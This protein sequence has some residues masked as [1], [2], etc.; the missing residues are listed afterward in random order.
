MADDTLTKAR[1]RPRRFGLGVGAVT[2]AMLLAAINYGN[3]LIFLLAFAMVALILNSAWQGWRALKAV[4]IQPLPPAMRPAGSLGEWP[5][6]LVS[7]P[8]L[9]AVEVG[10][11]GE[12]AA[13]AVTLPADEP[14]TVM[15][16]LPPAPRGYLPLPEVTLATRFPLGL[17]VIE[18]RLAPATG[19]WVYPAPIEGPSHENRPE[20]DS[21]TGSRPDPGGDPT[22]LRAY[23]PGDP[24]RRIVFRHY[25]KT[26][27][28]VSR[29]TEGEPR[30]VEPTIIDYDRYRGDRETRL[31]AMTDRLLSLAEAGEPWTLRLPGSPAVSASGTERETG[32]ARQ[33]ALRLLARFGRS[34]DPDGFDHVPPGTE[35]LP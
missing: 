24:M 1:I 27:R 19:Q 29:Q 21:D 6:R 25:A 9:P 2:A 14:V 31:S 33:R 34:R 28:L 4:R 32:Q 18:R 13:V 17:W 16:D 23:Q 5:L 20:A 8:G 15:L 35:E 10:I 3:N 26:G 7:R 30:P 11:E 12:A 22:H